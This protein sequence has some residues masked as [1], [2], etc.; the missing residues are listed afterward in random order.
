[1]AARVPM[2]CARLLRGMRAEAPF[3]LIFFAF[4]CLSVPGLR[5]DVNLDE[6]LTL[7][8]FVGFG[9]GYIVSNY[10]IPN[11][12]ILYN[13]FLWPLYAL[14][15]G[16]DAPMPLLRSLSLVASAAGLWA[17]YKGM[18]RWAGRTEA[19]LAAAF[20]GLS[21][22]NIIF[23]VQLRGYPLSAGLVC[24]G[25]FSLMRMTPENSQKNMGLFAL[26]AF[27]AVGVLPTNL[28][29]FVCVGLCFFQ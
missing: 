29:P 14:G 17:L 2:T 18:D 19:L 3:L 24:I 16:W 28:V 6:A 4:L 1:M 22:S 11:N 23:S 8:N 9:P 20:M 27:T 25:L 13:L 26:A 7:V 10:Y 5:R 12:H 15:G 21:H